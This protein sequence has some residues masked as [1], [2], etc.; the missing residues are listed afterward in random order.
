MTSTFQSNM[1]ALASALTPDDL[2]TLGAAQ[3]KMVSERTLRIDLAKPK[4]D[5]TNQIKITVEGGK[6]MVKGYKLEE[7]DIL[8]SVEA[9][10][11][12]TALNNLGCC[13]LP[14]IP[15]TF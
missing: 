13:D 14:A 6:F 4:A 1:Q 5:G 7:T 8:H 3:A 15:K 11:L 2:K 9:G 12:V 10:S